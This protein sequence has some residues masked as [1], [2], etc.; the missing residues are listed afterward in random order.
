MNV[1]TL[2]FCV[3]LLAIVNMA[4]WSAIN[5]LQVE[6]RQQHRRLTALEVFP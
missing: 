1:F 3:V 2:A 4:A 6:N 5:D